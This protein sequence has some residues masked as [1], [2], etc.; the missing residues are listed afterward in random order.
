MT[1]AATPPPENENEESNPVETPQEVSP[2][3][4][5]TQGLDEAAVQK[6]GLKG[7]LQR[8]T[9]AG[10]RERAVARSQGGAEVVQLVRSL[11]LWIAF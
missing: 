10:R 5:T 6:R 4:T 3:I 8:L 11:P 7:V 9:P 1:D 2:Q